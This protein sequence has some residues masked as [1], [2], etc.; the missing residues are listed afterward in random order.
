MFF[1]ARRG[2]N[3]IIDFLHCGVFDMTRP[4]EPV[5]LQLFFSVYAVVVSVCAYIY[6]Y[7]HACASATASANAFAEASADALKTPR[8]SLYRRVLGFSIGG[9]LLS[10]VIGFPMSVFITAVV[11]LLSSSHRYP[12]SYCVH[13]RNT[14]HSCTV[15]A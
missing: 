11:I 8:D 2:K 4:A 3:K 1:A 12:Q 7:A 10:L 5:E 9:V 15:S 13:D 6:A 14:T